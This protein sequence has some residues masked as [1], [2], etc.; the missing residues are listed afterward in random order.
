MRVVLGKVA[1]TVALA[2][3]LSLTAASGVLADGWPSCC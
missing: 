2:A 3:F 1:F